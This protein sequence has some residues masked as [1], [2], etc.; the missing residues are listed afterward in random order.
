M[1]FI[2]FLLFH[3]ANGGW[4]GFGSYTTC[5]S[6]CGMGTKTRTRSCTNPKPFGEGSPCSGS[7]SQSIAC[8]LGECPG[9]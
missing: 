8:N 7:N 5:S 1:S 3:E 6:T 4:S 9:E 2:K